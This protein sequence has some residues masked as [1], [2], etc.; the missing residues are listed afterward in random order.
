MANIAHGGR[1]YQSLWNYIRDQG[2]LGLSVRVDCDQ[3]AIARIYKA[4]KKEKWMD[5]TVKVA[6]YNAWV[7]SKVNLPTGF[8]VSYGPVT[9]HAVSTDDM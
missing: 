9:G 6:P 4:I 1:A 3:H 8:S 7:L 5:G 2:K